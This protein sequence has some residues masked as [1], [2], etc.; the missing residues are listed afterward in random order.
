MKYLRVVNS[1]VQEVFN[2]P[3]GVPIEECFT[4]VVVA[5]FEAYEGAAE[6]LWQKQPDGTFVAPPPVDN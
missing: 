1:V 3:D 5:A 6:I 4:P 2:T